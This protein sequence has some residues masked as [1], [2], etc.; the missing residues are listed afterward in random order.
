MGGAADIVARGTGVI[1][2]VVEEREMIV[3]LEAA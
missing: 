2:S 3:A 1:P